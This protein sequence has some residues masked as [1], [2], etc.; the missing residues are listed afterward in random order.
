MFAFCKRFILDEEGSE[1]L[2]AL[3]LIGLAAGLIAL[4]MEIASRT[5]IATENAQTVTKDYNIPKDKELLK[6]TG[7]SA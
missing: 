1:T 2:E 6:P 7:I 5:K 3:A 4:I